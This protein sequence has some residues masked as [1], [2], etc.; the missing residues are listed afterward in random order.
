MKKIK[1]AFLG[2][3]R[4]GRR[5]GRILLQGQHFPDM[6]LVAIG[7]YKHRLENITRRLRHDN[8]YGWVNQLPVLKGEKIG[9]GD[10]M[11][12]YLIGQSPEEFN[13]AEQD[14]D[15]VF[16]CTHKNRTHDKLARHL[17]QS[18]NKMGVILTCPPEDDTVKQYIAGVS[19]PK[20]D[21]I[22]SGSSCSTNALAVMI[23]KALLA[24]DHEEIREI[25]VI[26]YHSYTNSNSLLD[27]ANSGGKA[28]GIENNLV[29][30][31]T[32]AQKQITKIFP[33]L[34]GK[35]NIEC[36]RGHFGGSRIRFEVVRKRPLNINLRHNL[37]AQFSPDPTKLDK[38]NAIG[39]FEIDEWDN[40]K[41]IGN[42]ATIVID[43]NSRKA[44]E[45]AY[46]VNGYYDNEYGYAMN[47]LR[48]A[49]EQQKM[50]L[51]A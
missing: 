31:S 14:C 40:K 51:T 50:L 45:H 26:I 47:L 15:I 18:K 32:G 19:K 7:D 17:A 43:V 9:V 3:G 44:R 39:T 6:E 10:H 34:K 12:N 11:A 48:L 24:I 35:I 36:E 30:T 42:P 37:D 20:T 27:T 21:R 29:P 23:K 33:E 28:I 25:N 49:K 41:V 13:W 46:V 4:I 8:V 16:D 38:H 1:I 5:F 22:I 2:P